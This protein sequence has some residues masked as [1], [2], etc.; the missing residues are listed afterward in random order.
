MLCVVKGDRNLT[1]IAKIVQS[2]TE[3]EKVYKRTL[4]IVVISQM[5]GG[6]GLAAG[7]TVGALIAQDML[8]TTSFAG[9][10]SALFTLGSAL[11]AYFVGRIS[12]QL[13]RR[14]GLSLGFLAGSIGALGVIL[15]T[16]LGSISLL[17]FSL[18]I[19]GAGTSTNLQVRY[20]GADLAK[21]KQRATAVSIAMVSTT[22]GAVAGPNM[23][24]PMGKV[25]QMM[26]IPSLAGPFML[27]AF[28]YSL[29]GL[30][31]FFYMR[32]DPF[33]LAKALDKKRQTEK[34]ENEPQSEH[35]ITD[36]RAGIVVGALVLVLSHV[37]MVAIMTMT[38]IHMQEHGSG[39][40]A[41]GL[42]I[43]LHIAAMY[44]P[45]ILTGKLVDTIGR[46]K[47]IV[48]SGV[49]LAI[50]GIMVAYVPGGSLFWMAFALILLGVGWNFGLISGTAV[51][52]DSTTMSNRAKT[53]GTVDVLVALGGT[54]GSLL[55]GVIVAYSS[56]GFLGF[57]GTYLS[58]LLFPLI[59]WNRKQKRMRIKDEA[60]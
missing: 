20:A 56:Y 14:L 18:F 1:D 35:Q 25:A 27:A 46:N 5:F 29:A 42:V 11:S 52:V 50:T 36:S 3:V 24:T 4:T 55:S 53:Q 22:L 7:I 32:P 10:P 12:Q 6:A 40:T 17:F 30:T 57:L 43:G 34:L 19:Y 26:S 9:I 59:Y 38:P 39:L 8:G 51:I 23:V 58:L 41:V 28:A 44:L 48:A 13:G 15:A 2:P 60:S 54:A 37:V 31:L 47:M 49:T 45:S 21:P 16:V 33:L